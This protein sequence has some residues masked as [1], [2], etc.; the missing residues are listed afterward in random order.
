MMKEITPAEFLE[1]LKRGRWKFED[2]IIDGDFFVDCSDMTFNNNLYIDNWVVGGDLHISGLH[3]RI[4]GTFS[5][6]NCRVIG[7]LILDKVSSAFLFF[8]KA[9]ISGGLCLRY[10]RAGDISFDEV[11]TEK[12]VEFV[13]TSVDGQ[14]LCGKN[15]LLAL[16][17]FFYFGRGVV[18]DGSA[19]RE[20]V[21]SL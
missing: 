9:E 15:L 19:L 17:S 6:S 8:R 14:V 20:L 18:I 10:V 4:N 7:R 5:F 12:G 2:I 3:L 13:Y 16:Q 21:R 1:E 11:T